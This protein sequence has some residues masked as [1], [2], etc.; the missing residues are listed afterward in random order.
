MPHDRLWFA[1]PHPDT[2]I[3]AEAVRAHFRPQTESLEIGSSGA[4]THSASGEVA[5]VMHVIGSTS[6]A[7]SSTRHLAE[8]LWMLQQR[9]GF[10]T[11][12]GNRRPPSNGWQITAIDTVCRKRSV[13]GCSDTPDPHSFLGLEILIFHDSL[14][15]S[16]E[17][18]HERNS[19]K[20]PPALSA[21]YHAASYMQSP[22]QPRL[23]RHQEACTD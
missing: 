15:I 7:N 14:F 8:L 23:A 20:W 11:R 18:E 19:R 10:G 17:A 6:Q 16:D 12:G 4:D 3:A 2:D 22:K 5:S 13:R 1:V 9:T 21:C